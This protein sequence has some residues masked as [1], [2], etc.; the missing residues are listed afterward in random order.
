MARKMHDDALG[1]AGAETVIGSGV[2]LKGNIASDAD[3][4]ID[5]QLEGNI[6]ANGNVSVGI[7]AR[8]AGNISGADVAIA[9][10]LTGN[11][12]ALG[13]ASILPTGQVRGDITAGGLAITSGAI[14]V[15]HSQMISP[16]STG[17]PSES[18]TT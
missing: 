14:F 1:V 7:N 11:I 12:T 2:K 9:G 4:V 6:I 10:E 15:G 16:A 5:G 18:E 8:I 17:H 3:I 13:E